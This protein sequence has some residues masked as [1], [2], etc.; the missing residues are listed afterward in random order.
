MSIIIP[1]FNVEP[2]IV[3]CLNS[4]IAQ[5]YTGSM[6]CILV[7]DCSQDQSVT[8]ASK[9]IDAYR[10]PI[11]FRIVSHECN[12]GLSAAR[13]TGIE[14]SRGDYLYFL[15]SD[16][17]LDRDCIAAMVALVERHPGVEL[18][19]AGAVS[20]GGE[21]RT[22]LD[23][24]NKDLP[25]YIQG[26]DTVMSI[27]LNRKLMPVTAWN[28]LIKKEYLLQHHLFFQEG[29]I[30]EDELWTYQIA[31]CL[32]SLAI[33]KQN[34]YHYEFHDTGLMAST[35]SLKDESLV[36]IACQMITSMTD[37]C[38]YSTVPYITAFIQLRSFDVKDETQR[39]ALLDQMPRLFPYYSFFRKLQARVWLSL[40]KQPIRDHYW[41]YTLLYHWKI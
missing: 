10:G 32:S 15:D 18:V 4:V 37:N 17:W 24:Q 22:W 23:M 19:Q 12:R 40:C 33:L 6:E 35:N 20:H 28:R 30:H 36:G 34:T 29:L 31:L 21:E 41:L 3:R 5:E 11:L 39:M 9:I 27:L 16:D 1:V 25:E 2:Y 14:A 13:N 8:I 26:K 7:N 38:A